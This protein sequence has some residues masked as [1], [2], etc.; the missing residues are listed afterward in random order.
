MDTRTPA[1]RPDTS[2]ASPWNASARS[3]AIPR[4]CCVRG[5]RPS[6]GARRLTLQAT[7]GYKSALRERKAASDS[8]S[9]TRG[10]TTPSCFPPWCGPMPEA[11]SLHR[12]RATNTNARSWATFTV[13][14]MHALERSEGSSS[15]LISAVKTSAL[16]LPLEEPA[17]VSDLSTTSGQKIVRCGSSGA[18]NVGCGFRSLRPRR[19][20][21]ARSGLLPVA[22]PGSLG[23]NDRGRRGRNDH[24][25]LRV[26][27]I[28]PPRGWGPEADAAVSHQQEF[29][30]L[31]SLGAGSGARGAGL[32]RDYAWRLLVRY[33]RPV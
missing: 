30:E 13:A 7:S 28:L 6:P 1:M 15:P 24:R 32:R 12:C 14:A 11:A 25:R 20:E 19:L 18:C 16:H 17:T 21:G 23:R 26:L 22:R 31:G 2:S 3:R 33:R 27:A 4:W 10:M 29:L 8:C 5:C 9:G